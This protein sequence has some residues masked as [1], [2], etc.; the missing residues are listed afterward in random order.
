MLFLSLPPAAVAPCCVGMVGVE[1]REK[2]TFLSRAFLGSRGTV[3]LPA[4]IQLVPR[5][6]T[7]EWRRLLRC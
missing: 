5:G 7:G 4:V 2:D 3:G 1:L 6:A